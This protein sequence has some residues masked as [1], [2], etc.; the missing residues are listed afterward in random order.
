MFPTAAAV[1]FTALA[2]IWRRDDWLNTI[3]KLA[4]IALAVWGGIEAL[5]AWGFVLAPQS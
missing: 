4:F 3:L 1:A 5:L 2:A